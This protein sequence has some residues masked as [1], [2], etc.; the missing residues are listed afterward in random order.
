MNTNNSNQVQGFDNF[1]DCDYNL[2]WS[3]SNFNRNLIAANRIANLK[4]N[5]IVLELGAGT[6]PV[7]TLVHK[8]FK[9]P[10]IVFT[11]V[12]GDSKYTD[13]EGIYVFDITS[14]DFKEFIAESKYDAVVLMEVIEHIDEVD[15]L[16][17]IDYIYSILVKEGL[18]ILSTP[19]PPFY[20]KYE[21]RV[22]PT[23]HDFEYDY[24]DMYILLNKNF[25]VEKT[26]GWSLEEREYTHLLEENDFIRT[27]HAKL[28]GAFP[29]GF[30][31]SIISSLSPAVYCRQ[32]TYICK[33]RRISNN[34]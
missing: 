11:K 1:E 26:I 24:D 28:R 34:S 10:D 16:D 5:A 20:K 21:E 23:D 25:K 12:D 4:P 6:S 27:V 33:A 15:G 14:N 18:F 13:K 7:E 9:R 29:E 3:Y 8:N 19:T 17:L 22:W 32:M 31:K 2:A 30:I